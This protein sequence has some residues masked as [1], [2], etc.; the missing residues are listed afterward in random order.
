MPDTRSKR[1]LARRNWR[2]KK[3][4]GSER[5]KRLS[6]GLPAPLQR[7]RLERRKKRTDSEPSVMPK[8]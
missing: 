5:P 1:P 2:R 6:R 7:R 4:G 8:S 3:P